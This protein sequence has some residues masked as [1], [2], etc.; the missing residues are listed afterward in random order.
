MNDILKALIIMWLAFCAIT[1]WLMFAAFGLFAVFTDYSWMYS[2]TPY[3]GLSCVICIIRFGMTTLK[4]NPADY[5]KS[6]LEQ[7]FGKKKV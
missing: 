1:L 5:I 7:L 4:S 6:K 2:V 3:I